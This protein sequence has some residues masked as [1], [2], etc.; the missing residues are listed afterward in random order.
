VPVATSAGGGLSF[1]GSIGA[2][3]VGAS[4]AGVDVGDSLSGFPIS[5]RSGVVDLTDF[6]GWGCGYWMGERSR[7]LEGG[8]PLVGSREP[9]DG[10]W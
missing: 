10:I 3:G 8:G 1:V 5:V 2:S 6:G 9:P 4:D 7:I